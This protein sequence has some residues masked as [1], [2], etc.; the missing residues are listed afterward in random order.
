MVVC[1]RMVLY[2]HKVHLVALN[3]AQKTELWRYKHYISCNIEATTSFILHMSPRCT[4]VK[5]VS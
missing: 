4:A 3:K 1:D 2:F 5:Y